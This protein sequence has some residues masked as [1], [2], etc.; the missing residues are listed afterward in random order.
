M[1]LHGSV[2]ERHEASIIIFKALSLGKRFRYL[3]AS[4]VIGL[5]VYS[6]RIHTA[7]R[8]TP[9]LQFE[10]C[11]R[12][13]RKFCSDSDRWRRN[14]NHHRLAVRLRN[15]SSYIVQPSAGLISVTER[16]CQGAFISATV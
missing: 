14:G 10:C 5:C 15:V 6:E 3:G 8:R 16:W 12:C 7:V 4:C 9:N 1:Q 13:N 11:W 2:A